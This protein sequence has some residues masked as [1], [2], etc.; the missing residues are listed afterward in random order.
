MQQTKSPQPPPERLV[1]EF[2]SVTD[3]GVVAAVRR[4]VVVRQF[5]LF[6]CRDLR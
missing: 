1:T 2:A 6:A 4:D 5:Q 3:L